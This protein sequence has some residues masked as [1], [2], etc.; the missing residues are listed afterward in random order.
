[1]KR[2]SIP[3]M[4][5]L[6]ALGM[7]CVMGESAWGQGSPQDENLVPAVP[8]PPSAPSA[9]SASAADPAAQTGVEV[10]TRGPINEAFAQP[11]NTGA[12]RPLVVPKKPPEAIDEQP[13]D[14]KPA[15][16]NEAWIG[17]YWGWDDDRK[18]FLWVGG[19]WRVPPPGRQWVPGYWTQIS[20][21]FQWVP[22][23]WTP[24]GVQE[25]AYQPEPPESLE[26]GPTS[27]PPGDEYFWTPGCWRWRQTRYAWQPGFWA[28]AQPGW[29]WVPASYCWSPR[30][31]VFCNGYWDY[32]LGHRGLVFAPVYFAA[33]IL[34]RPHFVFSPTITLDAGLLNF[35]LFT[36]PNY[37][38]YY[39]GDYYAAGYDGL[40]IFPWF[41]VRAY[42]SYVCDPLFSYYECYNRRRDPDWLVNLNGW[43]QYY[44]THADMRPPHTLA[45]QQLLVAKG[46]TRPDREFLKIADPLA[47]LQRQPNGAIRLTSLSSEEKVKIHATSQQIT[48]SGV[49]RA[50]LET[51]GAGGA[52]GAAKTPVTMPLPKL[53]T[54]GLPAGKTVSGKAISGKASEAAA[55]SGAVTPPPTPESFESKKGAASK[56]V[57]SKVGPLGAEGSSTTKGTGKSS[58]TTERIVPERKIPKTPDATAP[59]TSSDRDSGVE[60]R[61]GSAGGKGKG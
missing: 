38:H 19:V 61:G 24:T 33:G 55:L 11:I 41:G 32:P 35:Y 23:F 8:P 1:M 53:P 29:L 46:G 51:K 60:L 45:A 5:G 56:S 3:M 37:C 54:I 22:G 14:A 17:G 47:E 18:D 31:W 50:V 57:L 44:R 59:K 4:C 12:Q 39:F 21:G 52:A 9:P 34:H 25:V 6:A 43:H 27:N 40:G 48:E 42:R 7:V 49:Q 16:A 15:D 13:P 28:V 2:Y 36:R 30:G 58:S 26:Q 20:G 10:M